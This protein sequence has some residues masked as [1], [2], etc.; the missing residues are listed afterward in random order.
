MGSVTMKYGRWFTALALAAAALCP[1]CRGEAQVVDGA[2][3]ADLD[4]FRTSFLNP[5][6]LSYLPNQLI[7]GSKAYEV[8][9]NSDFFDMSNGYVSYYSPYWRKRMGVSGQFLRTG[10]FILTDFAFSYSE[11]VHPLFSVGGRL[12]VISQD[13]DE[14][15]FQG[16]DPGDPVLSDGLTRN[17]F[18]LTVGILAVP[19]PELSLGAVF[20]NLNRPNV[21]LS[22]DGKFLLPVTCDL[23]AQYRMDRFR[24][25]AGLRYEDGVAR[26]SLRLGVILREDLLFRFDYRKEKVGFEGHMRLYRGLHLNYR[27]QYPLN[28]LN[29]FSSGSHSLSFIY[30]FTKIIDLPELADIHYEP[31][32]VAVIRSGR[33]IP[34]W[35]DFSVLPSTHSLEI[36]EKNI[37]RRADEDIPVDFLRRNYG[38][39]FGDSEQEPPADFSVQPFTPDTLEGLVGTYSKDYM[40]SLDSLSTVLGTSEGIEARIYTGEGDLPRAENIKDFIAARSQIP[41][42]RI[43]IL[44]RQ[45]SPVRSG[46]TGPPVAGYDSTA[47]AA[48]PADSAAAGAAGADSARQAVDLSLIGMTE[49]RI[50]LSQDDI[51]FRI[52]S[53]GKDDYSAPWSLDILD[54]SGSTVR[55]F[56]GTGAVPPVISWDWRDGSGNIIE[57]GWYT[58][59]FRWRGSGG[60]SMETPRGRIYVKKNKKDILI[61]LTRK[62]RVRDLDAQR[63]ELL[64]D[65]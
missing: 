12:D 41:P 44:R 37:T 59:V 61:E 26:L 33:D 29:T 17:Y 35:G 3:A 5:A 47:A 20:E 18:S 40:E 4:D 53:V 52:F 13:F 15:G 58:Y 22:P 49:R 1:A 48:V 21:S 25:S 27:Y 57:P 63:I 42:D 38:K 36:W 39:I 2:G 11:R 23:G 8:G 7:F 31:E 54:A 34:V 60:G 56:T 43:Q 30:D 6:S 28:E 51:D 24:P 62:R 10:L 16:V 46:G 32:P 14:S 9:L 45:D 65:Q 64:L 50:V 19:A 55:S